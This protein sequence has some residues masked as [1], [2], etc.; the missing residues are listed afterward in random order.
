LPAKGGEWFD[1]VRAIIDIEDIDALMG[2][3]SP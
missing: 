3:S 2:F 1:I